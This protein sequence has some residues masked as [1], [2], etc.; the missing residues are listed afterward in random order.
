MTFLQIAVVIISLLFI[1]TQNQLD[2]SNQFIFIFLLFILGVSRANNMVG[3]VLLVEHFPKKYTHYL[4]TLRNVGEFI[5]HISWILYFMVFD[6]PVF[7]YFPIFWLV[8]LIFFTWQGR[9]LIMESPYWLMS[10]GYF[11]QLLEYFQR[12]SKINNAEEKFNSYYEL[13]KS[14]FEND[15][16]ES[17][18]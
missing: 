10:K 3:M 5:I 13:N 6:K 12:V 15:R 17:F 1:L 8:L 9:K 14:Q 4:C 11:R 16:P 7:F 18:N 2:D